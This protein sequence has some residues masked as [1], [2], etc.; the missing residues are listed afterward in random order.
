MTMRAGAVTAAV[1]LIVFGKAAPIM[2][3]P[4]ATSTSRNVPYSSETS[5]RHS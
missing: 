2:P 1:R 4:A 5:R 3:P